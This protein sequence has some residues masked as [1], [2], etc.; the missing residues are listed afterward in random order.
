MLISKA[1]LQSII[2]ASKE[3]GRHAIQGL[4]ITGNEVIATDGHRLN[5]V[6]HGTPLV[7]EFDVFGSLTSPTTLPAILDGDSVRTILKAWPKVGKR[8]QQDYH[9]WGFLS[10]T[11]F[12]VIDANNNLFPLP[13][14]WVD[15]KF[16]SWEQVVPSEEDRPFRM[17]LDAKY[18]SDAKYL[19]DNHSRLLDI[20]LLD[21]N[22]SA[23]IMG[24][25]LQDQK[26]RHIIMP[27][28]LEQTDQ[29]KAIVELEQ[30]YTDKLHYAGI[31]TLQGVLDPIKESDLIE[32]DGRKYLKREVDA[33]L[34]SLQQPA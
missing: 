3:E 34:E 1:Q 30:E 22:H 23:L 19:A 13:V 18:L 31:N 27:M 4:C 15:G 21:R 28:R 14:N 25:N 20:R 6:E 7:P 32:I 11:T 16:P 29:D 26:T 2:F 9:N 10:V 8:F 12:T 5:V 33:K 17:G 24:E